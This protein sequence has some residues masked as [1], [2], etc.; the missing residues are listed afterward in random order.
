MADRPRGGPDRA[1]PRVAIDA[2]VRVL[3]PDPE[4]REYVFRTRDL[5]PGGLFLYT[6]VGHLYPFRVGAA[7]SIELYDF[8]RAVD[9]KAVVV[10]VVEPGS[11]EAERFPMG[12]GVKVI[13]ID[14]GNRARLEE[15]LKRAASGEDP[16]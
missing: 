16:Y 6:R 13:E 12:F 7:L 15:L 3:G 14:D 8:D 2:F 5:S 9:F 11:P 1:Y 10:R 4:G